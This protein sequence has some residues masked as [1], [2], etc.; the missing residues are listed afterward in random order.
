MSTKEKIKVVID[1]SI[2][3]TGGNAV[4]FANRTGNGPT[5]LQNEEGYRCCLGFV[6]LAAGFSEEDIINQARPID[7]HKVT[8]GLTQHSDTGLRATDVERTAVRINDDIV[9]TPKEKEEIL[10]RTFEDSIYELEFVGEYPAR[11]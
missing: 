8:P 3:R 6:C 5:R 7:L 10:L 2:W 1:R 11:G 9:T 4:N